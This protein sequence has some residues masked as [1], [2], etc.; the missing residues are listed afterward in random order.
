MD[1]SIVNFNTTDIT[2]NCLNSIVLQNSDLIYDI[3]L[4]DT[5]QKLMRK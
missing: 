1:I 2:Y 5:H 3:V 4:V